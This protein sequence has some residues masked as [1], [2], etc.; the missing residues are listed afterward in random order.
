LWVRLNDEELS[1]LR[2]TVRTHEMAR[3]QA[4]LQRSNDE[5]AALLEEKEER[6]LCSV[7]LDHAKNCALG[8][9]HQLCEGCARQIQAAG[10]TCPQCR[11]PVRTLTRLYY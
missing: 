10:Q 9:G 11:E 1:D 3:V 7:C 2:E 4:R 5:R 8:C 6:L